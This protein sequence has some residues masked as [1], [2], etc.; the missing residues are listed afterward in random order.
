MK[1]S[2]QAKATFLAAVT[3][4]L[5]LVSIDAVFLRAQKAHFSAVARRFDQAVMKSWMETVRSSVRKRDLRSLNNKARVMTF[6]DGGAAY[7]YI[8]SPSGSFIVHSE[9]EYLWRPLEEWKA[10][11]DRKGVREM[12]GTVPIYGTKEAKV[13]VGFRTGAADAMYKVQARDVMPPLITINVTI[14]VFIILI[15]LLVSRRI[16]WPVRQLAGAAREISAGK[17]KTQVPV[18]SADEI[19]ALQGEFN[20]MAKRLGE[21]DELKSEFL[22]KITHDLR[23]PLGAIMG[24]AEVLLMGIKGPLTPQQKHSLETM[25]LNAG[26][27]SELINNILDVTKLEAGRM[28]YSKEELDIGEAAASV[29][30]LM[31]VKAA[32]YGV[33]LTAQAQDGLPPAHGDSQAI[34]RVLTNLVSNALKFTPKGGSVVLQAT[35]SSD[36]GVTV[37]VRDTGIGIPA[38]KMARVF[39]KFAQVHK[40][41]DLPR[42]VPGT[43]LGL[44]ICKEVVEGHGG[45]IWVESEPGKGTAFFF[46]LPPASK[47]AGAA[48]AGAKSKA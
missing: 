31:Q 41:A 37:A 14:V 15:S 26:Y 23:N 5:A 42:R 21:L 12:T 25:Q 22:A 46:S 17:F 10:L 39:S 1:L 38:D 27:L 19:G 36:G 48:A 44:V 45:R 11:G 35:A 24:Y 47:A 20:S 33:A 34:R 7:V 8:V 4:L 13:V 40:G 9:P 18:E 2:L 32:E 28:E 16:I 30:Q 29:A 3:A 43:G 6:G